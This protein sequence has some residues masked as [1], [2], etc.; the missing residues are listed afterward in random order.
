M[1]NS[2]GFKNQTLNFGSFVGCLGFV[3]FCGS[4]LSSYT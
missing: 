3:G 2:D 1:L 4:Y